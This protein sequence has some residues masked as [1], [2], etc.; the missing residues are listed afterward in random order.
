MPTRLCLESGCA[1]PAVTRGRCAR[2]AA[3]QRKANRSRFD[4]FYASKPWAMSRRQQLYAYPLCQFRLED[5][6]ECD[7]IADS[8]HHIIELEHGGRPRDPENLMSLCRSHHSKLHAARRQ[9]ASQRL[10]G[11]V[12]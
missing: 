3:A 6:T 12:W 5:G 10:S 8:V 2:H 1:N 9:N 7:H 4:S 11:G